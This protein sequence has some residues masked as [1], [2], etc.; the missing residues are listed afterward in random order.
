MRETE[1]A[2]LPGCLRDAEKRVI[3]FECVERVVLV[4]CVG[5]KGRGAR[6]CCVCAMQHTPLSN[7]K[8]HRTS[9]VKAPRLARVSAMLRRVGC[10]TARRFCASS[11]LS[12]LFRGAPTSPGDLTISSQNARA[13]RPTYA[14]IASKRRSLAPPPSL[15]APQPL[16]APALARQKKQHHTS[17]A[18][19]QLRV[20]ARARQGPLSRSSFL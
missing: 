8:A 18:R 12:F 4:G 16:S 9:F 5:R 20:C 13:R 7:A 19:L 17:I 10:E 1:A 15:L 14:Q 6:A 2:L 11:P 3:I